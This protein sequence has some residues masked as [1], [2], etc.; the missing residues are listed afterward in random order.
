[1]YYLA[2]SVGDLA[3]VVPSQLHRYA[4]GR[5]SLLDC[6]AASGQGENE[7]LEGNI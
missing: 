4:D 1:M 5:A 3:D 2:A 6:A 7:L